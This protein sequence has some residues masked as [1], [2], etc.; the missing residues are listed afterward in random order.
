VRKDQKLLLLTQTSLA[1]PLAPAHLK[2]DSNLRFL[3]H[4]CCSVAGTV[5]S[6]L[7]KA[8]VAACYRYHNLSGKLK[9]VVNRTC[10]K[11]YY[12]VN[13]MLAALYTRAFFCQETF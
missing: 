5:I 9:K 3:K 7:K 10:E 12:Y 1:I 6:V 11:E 8:R 2:S 4:A 13:K